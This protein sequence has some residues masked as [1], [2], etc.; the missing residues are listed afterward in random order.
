MRKGTMMGKKRSL[1]ITKQAQQ[2]IQRG[3]PLL[4]ELSF[5]ETITFK[6][7]ELVELTDP[8]G[9]FVAL[10]YLAKQNKGVGWV[11]STQKHTEFDRSFF[12]Q[13]FY[14]AKEKRQRLWTDEET[15]AFRLINAEG[16]GIPGVTV[17]HYAGFA[18]FSWYSEGIFLYR[19][20]IVAAFQ[21]IFPSIKGAYEKFRYQRDDEEVSGHLYGEKA[22]TPLLV[23]ENGIQYAVYLNE[24][25]MTGIF[26]DQRQ[27]RRSLMEKYAAGKTVLN[28]FSYTGAFS[29]AAAMGGAAH[30]VSVDVAKRS[31][32]KTKE[33]FIVNG[34]DPEEQ[35]IRVMDV[36]DYLQ[37]AKRKQLQFDVLISDPPS[38]ARTK[39]RTFSVLKDYSKLVEDFIDV[40]APGA[41]FIFSTNAANYK[42]KA[43]KADIQK[44]FQK[45]NMDVEI[46]EGFYLPEDFPYPK[47]SNTSDYLKVWIVQRK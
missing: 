8:K 26:L 9:N 30:T 25:W 38:F 14:Q 33:Q 42:R 28:T 34:L 36:F 10:A 44:S 6:E 19:K 1:I 29:V 39:K 11:Y 15:D 21:E 4:Q 46:L 40:S 31:L 2:N 20:E 35:T 23:K 41:I 22:E 16:D 18:V 24:G 3:N 37:Y 12:L 7:G 5:Q 45:K 13:Q 27:V 47:G 43:F 17:D 32:E